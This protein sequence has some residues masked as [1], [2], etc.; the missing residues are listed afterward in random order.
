MSREK[1]ILSVTFELKKV[2]ATVHQLNKA[3]VSLFELLISNKLNLY[4][5]EDKTKCILSWI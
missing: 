2:H 4:F 3:F 1:N 5:D